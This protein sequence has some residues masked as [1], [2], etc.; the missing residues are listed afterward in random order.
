MQ[1]QRDEEAERARLTAAL[2]TARDR[3]PQLPHLEKRLHEDLER[4]EQRLAA[5]EQARDE[6]ARLREA[7]LAE[8]PPLREIAELSAERAA[9]SALVPKLEARLGDWPPIATVEGHRAG[10]ARPRR[11]GDAAHEAARL[12]GEIESLRRDHRAAEARLQE[13]IQTLQLDSASWPPRVDALNAQADALRDQLE[14]EAVRRARRVSS[15]RRRAPSGPGDDS[16]GAPGVGRRGRGAARGHRQAGGWRRRRSACAARARGGD[17]GSAAQEA[18]AGCQA[19]K[20]AADAALVAAE[21]ALSESRAQSVRLEGE[22][23]EVGTSAKSACRRVEELSALHQ[24]A[25]GVERGV[26]DKAERERSKLALALAS[27]RERSQTFAEATF[28][29]QARLVEQQQQQQQ[30][31]LSAQQ[32]REEA[33]RQQD[34]AL[35]KSRAAADERERHGARMA[36]ASASSAVDHVYARA[37][38]AAATGRS[39]VVTNPPLRT[40]VAAKSISEIRSL[41][42]LQAPSA[43][44]PPSYSRASGISTS[45]RSSAAARRRASAEAAA[46]SGAE[47]LLPPSS[48]NGMAAV[49]CRRAGHPRSSSIGGASAQP[50]AW[51]WG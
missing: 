38:R 51:W 20:R 42:D 50:N 39:D 19:E 18:L 27:E 16:S 22:L 49:A 28:L 17:V 24:H 23:R 43:T 36:A 5:A 12:R 21:K 6:A 48:S 4:L 10:G 8:M 41:L 9:L 11:A 13:R 15:C 1:K 30:Q 25:L 7:T 14:R 45:S 37:R 26:E 29:Q 3:P 46:P 31:Q 2:A 33:A 32:K 44:A 40:A 35:H 34:E 47:Q